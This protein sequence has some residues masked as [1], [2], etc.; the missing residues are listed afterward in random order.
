MKASDGMLYGTTQYYSACPTLT[1]L[2]GCIVRFNP[3]NNSFNYIFPFNCTYFDGASPTGSLVEAA[4]GKLYGTTQHGG[5]HGYVN[6]S[7]GDGTLFEYDIA[8][9]TFT[10]K[11]SFNRDTTG[12]YPGPLTMGPNNKL[13][14]VLGSYG[15]DPDDPDPNNEVKGAIY[16]YDPVTNVVTVLYY[17][18]DAAPNIFMMGHTPTGALLKASNDIFY[19]INSNGVFKFNPVTATVTLPEPS[20]LENFYP[21]TSGDLIEICRKPSYAYFE[22][23]SF[24]ECT[25][26]D[27]VF[28]VQNTN[29]TSYI[30]KK[31][32][33]ELASQTSAVLT[34][35]NLV[36]SDSGNYTCEMVNECGTTETMP[37]DLVVEV[38]MGLDDVVRT[39]NAIKLYPNPAK[40]VLNI[41]PE[42]SV[43]VIGEVRIT[44][45][46]G[47]SIY[48]NINGGRVIDISN[49]AAGMYLIK[50]VTNKG[51]WLGKFVKY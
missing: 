48:N 15:N 19:G 4:P 50:I 10:K 41:L 47:Q 2:L 8:T 26:T 35:N 9:N 6:G 3:N 1:P 28:D 16:E 25:E 21:H 31:D 42:S 27:F 14:G 51:D 11:F 40:D 17:F 5:D 37:I 43:L 24:T 36:I 45:S 44:N 32:G 23:T 46:L 18:S 13:Y 22:N 20:T 38:C 7:I 12:A 33:Q 29:A 49:F 34:L 30:W 39:K